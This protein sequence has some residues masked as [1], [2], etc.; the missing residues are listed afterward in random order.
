MK[1]NKKEKQ[2]SSYQEWRKNPTPENMSALLKSLDSTINSIAST[3][4]ASNDENLKWALRVHLAKEI[5]NRFDPS[6]SSLQ[7][8]VYQSL[9]RTPRIKAQQKNIIRVPESSDYDIRR[10]N[11]A[12]QEL[13]DINDR[14]PTR[15]EI[16]DR[17]GIPL[18]RI[19]KLEERYSKPTM[20]L[21]SF[22]QETGGVDPSDSMHIPATA[23]EQLYHQYS[24]D[25]LDSVDRRI[26]DS[27]SQNQGMS[28]KEL[29]SSL[30]L[31][32]PAVSQRIEKINKA[33]TFDV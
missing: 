7:T 8:F 27:L 11:A 29:A 19:Q 9:Q 3:H 31:S 15:A 13:I 24:V 17:A 25:S 28:K 26:Y 30:G 10:I 12:K 2:N 22:Y 18:S 23:E 4:G 33:L 20:N 5:K 6:K 16:S 32:A 21:S 1:K 14:E